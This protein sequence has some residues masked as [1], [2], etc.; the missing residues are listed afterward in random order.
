MHL[1]L[2][3]NTS[4]LTFIFE[5][6]QMILMFLNLDISSSFKTAVHFLYP[7][8]FLVF[9]IVLDEHSKI[10]HFNPYNP[11][12]NHLG[13]LLLK[14][15]S[16]HLTEVYPRNCYQSLCSTATSPHDKSVVLP[17][18]HAV[19]FPGGWLL[20]CTSTSIARQGHRCR[21]M[22]NPC[23]AVTRINVN[24]NSKDTNTC[25]S[26]EYT[27][28]HTQNYHSHRHSQTFPTFSF[29]KSQ[30]DHEHVTKITFF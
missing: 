19:K 3:T 23:F 10:L 8:S 7:C 22:P 21:D 11:N 4:C 15:A 29:L 24:S 13:G 16:W 27:H 2:S 26:T 18:Y 25:M 28:R 20:Q 1:T 6:F 9:S 12:S 30:L 14:H 5:Q 17:Y